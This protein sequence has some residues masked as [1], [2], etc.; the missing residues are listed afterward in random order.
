MINLYFE[1]LFSQLF[2]TKSKDK[3][4]YS[5]CA[6]LEMQNPVVYGVNRDLILYVVPPIWM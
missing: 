6:N 3:P 5:I 2:I 4:R 1:N